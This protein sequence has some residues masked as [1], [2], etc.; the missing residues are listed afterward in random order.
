MA[1]ALADNMLH[2]IIVRLVNFESSIIIPTPSL[3]GLI[4]AV[5]FRSGR[6]RLSTAAMRPRASLSCRNLPRR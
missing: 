4:A 2:F 6:R 1:D 3:F 5:P